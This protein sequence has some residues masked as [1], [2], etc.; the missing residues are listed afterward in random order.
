MSSLSGSSVVSVVGWDT[1][2]KK[3]TWLGQVA[4]HA[5]SSIAGL[6]KLSMKK[7][8]SAIP[9][10]VA[11]FLFLLSPLK[12]SA[13]GSTLYESAPTNWDNMGASGFRQ[14]GSS[15]VPASDLYAC[16]LG[17]AMGNFNGDTDAWTINLRQGGTNPSN[18]ALISSVSTVPAE[19]PNGTTPAITDFNLD[20]CTNLTA[21]Q[22]YFVEMVQPDADFTQWKMGKILTGTHA[23]QSSVW[24]YNGTVWAQFTGDQE[25]SIRFKGDYTSV[26]FN[27]LVNGGTYADFNN[28]DVT[29]GYPDNNSVVR[30]NYEFAG[31]GTPYVDTATWH[32]PLSSTAFQ[33]PKSQPLWRIP[34]TYQTQWIASIFVYDSTGSTVVASSTPIGFTINGAVAVSYTPTSTTPYSF[35]TSTAAFNY[36]TIVCDEDVGFWGG[37][38]CNFRKAGVWILQVLFVPGQYSIG[39]IQSAYAQFQEVFPFNIFFGLNTIVQDSISSYDDSGLTLSLPLNFPGYASSSVAVLTPTILATHGFGSTALN[40]WF[41]LIIMGVILLFVRGVWHLVHPH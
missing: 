33:I 38:G 15:F 23:E 12:V 14:F 20:F 37:L 19:W 21:G 35:S 16:S 8:L 9:P 34:Y 4:S 27:T 5:N 13:F 26:A 41:N 28:W 24:F 25:L 39:F 36:D 3:A 31:G 17:L 10:I 1:R 6:C 18:G 11:V 2:Q 7:L 22:T 30:V 32:P 40:W 29:L